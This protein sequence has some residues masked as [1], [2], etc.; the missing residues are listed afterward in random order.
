ME[1]LGLRVGGAVM[2]GVGVG[3][4]SRQSWG[5]AASL[6]CGLHSPVQWLRAATPRLVMKVK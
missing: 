6:E 1:R 4:A 2:G 5:F 3:F